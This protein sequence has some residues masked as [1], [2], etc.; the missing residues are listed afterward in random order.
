[1]NFKKYITRLYL[2]ASLVLISFNLAS[3]TVILYTPNGSTV[4]A[5]NNP[6]M[7]PSD[8]TY[9]TEQC[10][11][12]YPQAEVLA[13]ASATYNC[14]SYAWNLTEGGSIVCWLN[15]SP[16]LHKYWDDGSY[17]ETTEGNAEKIFYYAGDHSAVASSIPGK[18][19]SKWG[20][21]PLMRHA[22]EYGPT[23]YQM[24]NRK[25]YQKA[26]N[27]SISGASSICEQGTYNLN[28]LPAGATVNWIG[29]KALSI[30]SGQ[31]TTSVVCQKTMFALGGSTLKLRAVIT[32]F[33]GQTIE[34]E[35][36]IFVGTA[37]PAILLCPASE[38][39]YFNS[40]LQ[41]GYVNEDYYLY[42]YGTNLS[43]NDADYRWKFYSS[44]PYE[45]PVSGI[46]RQIEFRKSTPGDYTISVQYNGECGWS[47]ET[48]ETIRIEDNL[49]LNVYPNPV[50]NILT[51]EITSA[52]TKSNA[53]LTA[54]SPDVQSLSIQFWHK[55]LGHL[56]TTEI[57]ESIQQISTQG[58]PS[59]IYIV[60][61]IRDG[62]TIQN[63]TIMKK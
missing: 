1:M 17:I 22:P 58:L 33:T 18:Y 54:S 46:G 15:Q 5:F 16:D 42:A 47:E 9:Y 61:L 14:H 39:P 51:I 36:D 35:K 34:L 26:L 25:Y 32:L 63:K 12:S 29:S 56:R 20:S 52:G 40:H 28:N 2:L 62:K 44:N 38:Y 55:D 37:E 7:S 41:Y 57:S 49:N 24:T 19:E 53:F 27:I 3:Q 50:A 4:E 6:E 45:L 13:N 11:N 10:R 21:M 59:G 48:Y 30:V 8:I 23:S 60:L 43:N 31:G